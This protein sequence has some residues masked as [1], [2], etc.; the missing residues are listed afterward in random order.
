MAI[1]FRSDVTLSAPIGPRVVRKLANPAVVRYYSA[2]AATVAD[3]N[4]VLSLS[5]SGGDNF[6]LNSAST[7]AS[8]VLRTDG[9]IPHL[10]FD[11]VNDRMDASIGRSQPM[12][13]MVVARVPSAPEGNFNLGNLH[14]VPGGRGILITPARTVSAQFPS[15]VSTGISV[16]DGGWHIFT[17][18]VN[19]TSSIVGVDD[20]EVTGDL[21]S[22]TAAGFTI[23]RDGAGTGFAEMDIS[24]I[25]FW[26]SALN[27][28][29]RGWERDS[30][31][32]FYGIS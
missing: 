14:T 24:E 4:G 7:S 26:P 22:G 16:A 19:G 21:G 13:L 30:I 15:L 2:S 5:S 20:A 25:I 32:K 29:G 6:A 10:H 3:D 11:G 27:T 18:V 1:I 8:P 31:R 12:T 23:G 9:A 28:V 17:L